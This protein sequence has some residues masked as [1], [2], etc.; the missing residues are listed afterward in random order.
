MMTGDSG[1]FNPPPKRLRRAWQMRIRRWLW[2]MDIHPSALIAATAYIDRTWP[3]GVHIG[4]GSLID[5][6]AV[7]LTHDMT[8]GLYLDTFIGR[9]SYVGPRAIIL[10]GVTI[11][12]GAIIEPGAIVTKSVAGGARVAG[13]PAQPVTG[14]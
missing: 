8:R 7:I 13:N 1:T 10:P 4:A 14:D 9:R 5:E 6:E 2:G 3:K 11:G 12:D